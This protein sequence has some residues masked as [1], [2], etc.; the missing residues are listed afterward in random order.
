VTAPIPLALVDLDDTLFQTEAKCPEAERPHL[1]RCAVAGNDRHSYATRPQA[2]L[3]AWLAATT[4][5]VPV[6]ARGSDAFSRVALPF[7]HGAVLANG[8]VVLM[9]DGTV[10]P[11]WR[12]TVRAGLLDALPTMQ[13]LLSVGRDRA[14]H[15]GLDLRSW[16]VTEDGTAA[17]VVFKDNADV[18]GSGLADLA[19]MMPAPLGW[20]LHRNGNN[21]AYIPPCIS[22]RLACERL[23]GRARAA[24][25]ARP[26]LGFGDSLSD[27]AFMGLCD[28]LATPGRGQ[29]AD[30][31]LGLSHAPAQAPLKLLRTA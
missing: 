28:V 14:L 26:V 18:S 20:T 16:L 17:Y 24:D 3:F 19:A 27:L 29:I 31:L 8:A 13:S 9:P 10:D 4:E 7:R 12:E 11:E 25:P 5:L 15:A 30:A 1:V 6:T 2:T 21:M 23:V 22:K